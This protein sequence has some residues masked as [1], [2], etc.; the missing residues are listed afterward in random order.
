MPAQP[1]EAHPNGTSRLSELRLRWA[2]NSH[3]WNPTENQLSKFIANLPTEDQKTCNRFLHLE[4]R[5]RA[6][7]SR[8]LQRAFGSKA[9]KQPLADVV[10][11][12]T[13]RGKPFFLHDHP[14]SRSLNFNVSHEVR[15]PSCLTY[16]IPRRHHAIIAGC[17][18]LE[19]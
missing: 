6:V 5:K 16:R 3:A 18:C 17:W 13:R 19:G 10:I 4:D 11:A 9:F 8:M 2:F 7:A 15:A 14:V 12:R 1:Q